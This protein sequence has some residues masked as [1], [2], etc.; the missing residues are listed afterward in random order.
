MTT[1]TIRTLAWTGGLALVAVGGLGA[2]QA[3]EGT[4]PADSPA[5]GF[6]SLQ[7][8]LI[9]DFLGT[10]V[11]VGLC[12]VAAVMVAGVAGKWLRSGGGMGR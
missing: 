7:S 6:L 1:G 9:G 11:F 3:Q 2:L 10:L 12:A 8:F 4:L 5:Q